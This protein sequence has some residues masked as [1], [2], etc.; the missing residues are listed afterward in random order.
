MNPYFLQNITITIIIYFEAQ[1]V[2]DLVSGSLL[3]WLL[4][5]FDIFPSF[6]EYLLTFWQKKKKDIAGLFYIFSVVLPE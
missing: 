1:L 4:Y 2:P 3:C 6:F 5:S